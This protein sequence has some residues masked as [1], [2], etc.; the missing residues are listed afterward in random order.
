MYYKSLRIGKNGK[1]GW[2]IVD[3]TGKIVNMSPRKEELKGLE[4]EYYRMKSRERYTNEELLDFLREFDKEN[5]IVPVRTDFVNNP[6]YPSFMTYQRQFGSWNKA[7]KLVGLDT[8]AMVKRGIIQN[9]L[10]KGRL[11]EISVIEHFENR[12][13]DLSGEN[14]HSPCDGICPNGQTYE[15]KS[16]KL[17]EEKYWIFSTANK[18]KEEIEIYYFGAFNSDWTELEYAW[19]VP[20][21]IVESDNFYV[22]M[23]GGKFNVRNMK[24]YDITDKFDKIY[25]IPM[26]LGVRIEKGIEKVI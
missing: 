23:Y 3:E 10:Q 2:R 25:S 17:Y 21:E 24:K 16:S 9:N 19:R 13:K 26:T 7:L 4:E 1:P 20:G 6:E 18:Y 8:E 14:S 11:W 12:P 15:V 22:G 5:G